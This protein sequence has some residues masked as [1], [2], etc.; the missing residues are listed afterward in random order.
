MGAQYILYAS[1]TVRGPLTSRQGPFAYRV[2]ATPGCRSRL[3]KMNV[4]VNTPVRYGWRDNAGDH[5]LTLVW[6]LMADPAEALVR[7]AACAAG[8]TITGICTAGSGGGTASRP[9]RTMAASGSASCSHPVCN[10]A[11]HGMEA[12]YAVRP[13]INGGRAT[14]NDQRTT[15]TSRR[16]RRSGS[17][18]AGRRSTARRRETPAPPPAPW[19]SPAPLRCRR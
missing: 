2:V 12:R 10:V 11:A 5:D 4:S 13:A 15:V 7:N 9:T 16:A 6:V 18:A 1:G 3:L 8:A 14:D 19:L 17:P